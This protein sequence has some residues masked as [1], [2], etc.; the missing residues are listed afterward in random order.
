VENGDNKKLIQIEAK[1]SVT[2]T[3]YFQ[4]SMYISHLKSSN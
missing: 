2:V 1:Q 4:E 3:H